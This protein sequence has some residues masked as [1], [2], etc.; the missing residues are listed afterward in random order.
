MEA[1]LQGV[2]E[3]RA[4]LMAV[5]AEAELFNDV[6]LVAQL[7]AKLPASGQERWHQDRTDP[8]FVKSQKK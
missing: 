2:N 8:E 7:V 5:E 6:A 4:I 1:L 3:A